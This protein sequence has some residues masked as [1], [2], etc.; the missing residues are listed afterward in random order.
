MNFEA[1]R[2]AGRSLRGSR[3]GRLLSGSGANLLSLVFLVIIQL[4]SVPVFVTAFGIERYGVWL[5]LSTIPSY[6]ILSDI[7]LITAAQ[8][9][10]AMK[11]SAGKTDEVLVVFQ[12]VSLA[13][14]L[15]FATVALVAALA[16]LFLN[17]LDGFWPEE[18]APHVWAIPLLACYAALFMITFLPVSA[19]RATGYYARATIM[20]DTATFLESVAMMVAAMLTQSLVATALAPVIV[21][22]IALPLIY[23]QM[24]SLRPYFVWGVSHAT[25]AEIRRL[26]PAA[27]SCMAIPIGLA[28]NL[29]GAVLVVG[30][31]LGPVAV[32]LFVPVRT[33]SRLAVQLLGVVN[34]AIVPELS[35]ARGRNDAIA[36]RRYWRFSEMLAWL[37]LTPAAIGFALFGSQAV[38]VWTGGLLHPPALFVAIMAATILLHGLWFYP[39]MLITATN[40]HVSLAKYLVTI[41]IAGLLLA[42]LL[43]R[44]WGLA[45]VAA[46]IVAVDLLLVLMVWRFVRRMPSQAGKRAMEEI[47]VQLPY[48]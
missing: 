18:I 44:D 36:E 21:R 14:V 9:D 17:R 20:H 47:G 34:R 11:A 1:V 24:R 46:S 28:L 10:I 37:I 22:S 41:P 3:R 45:G 38:A 7:G 27:V 13:V 4:V 29:Q 25:R 32:A 15:V 8:N 42:I 43:V 2:A 48:E 23:W 35:A 39:V 40:D 6:L 19:L 26:L 30:T 33:A 16:V 5:I 12:S 31:F